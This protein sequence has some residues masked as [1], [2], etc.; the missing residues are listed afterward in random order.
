LEDVKVGMGGKVGVGDPRSLVVSGND[1]YRYAIFS[2]LKQ[3]SEGL[4]YQ[5]RWDPGSVEEV[6]SMDHQVDP[7]GQSVP[8]GLLVVGQEIVASP[9]SFDARA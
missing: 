3:A 5:R 1:E 2:H 6:A 7:G 4:E 9:P 8:Q